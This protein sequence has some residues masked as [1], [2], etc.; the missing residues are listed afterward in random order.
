L[1]IKTN[2]ALLS[3]I[4]GGILTNWKILSLALFLF[5]V[6]SII[7][8]YIRSWYRLRH[9]KGPTLA[10]FSDWWLIRSVTGGKAHLDFFD[11]TE[12]YG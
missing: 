3:D 4:L 11:I 2:M 8:Q 6:L 10:T 9:F 7:A 12:K 1:L 5:A